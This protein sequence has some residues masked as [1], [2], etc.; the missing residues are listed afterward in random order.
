MIE[1][2]F[3]PEVLSV[4]Q[5]ATADEVAIILNRSQAKQCQLDPAPTWLVKCAGGILA[6]VIAH[7]CNALFQQSAL[8]A[9]SKRAIVRPLPIPEEVIARPE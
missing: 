1:V 6:P 2:R 7:M 4:F 3:I 9:N 8:P 5:P